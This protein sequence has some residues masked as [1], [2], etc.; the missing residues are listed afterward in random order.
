MVP[1]HHHY[2]LKFIILLILI[3]AV[4]KVAPSINNWA[5][6]HN[7]KS[8]GLTSNIP[9]ASNNTTD[10]P[11]KTVQPQKS[12]TAPKGEAVEPE[13]FYKDLIRN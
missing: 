2:F 11:F 13:Q 6:E 8:D 9:R 1:V 10:Y 4:S 12:I 3:W 5:A 7:F